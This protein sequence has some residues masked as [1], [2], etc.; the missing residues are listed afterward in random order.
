MNRGWSRKIGLVFILLACIL[1]SN[2]YADKSNRRDK[3]VVA[4]EK[5]SPAVVNISTYQKAAYR[6]N[7][8]FGFRDSIFDEFFKNFFHGVPEEGKKDYERSLGSGV[9]LSRKG[10]VLTNEHVVLKSTKIVV[11]TMDGTSYEAE[12]IGSDGTSDIAVLKIKLQKLLPSV[13]L[14]NSDDLMIGEKVIA[15][16]N[17]FKLSHT[18]TTGVISAQGR[19]LKVGNRVYTNFIQTDTSI[20]PGNSGGPLIN[21]DGEVIGINT[22]IMSPQKS[23]GIGFAIPMN[24]AKRILDDLIAFGKVRKAWIGI[25]IQDLNPILKKNF[26]YQKNH[27][28]IVN[29]VEKK[30]PAE[31]SKIFIGDIIEKIG[32]S[33]I[34]SGNDFYN[35]LNEYTAS[36]RIVFTV[37][38]DG[39]SRIVDVIARPF[40]DNYALNIARNLI[41]IKVKDYKKYG[42][43][44]SFIASK[45]IAEKIGFA[46][47]DVII[48]IDR[49]R[50]K[51]V[52]D[53]KDAMINVRFKN[54]I[55]IEI[56]RGRYIY[57]TSI[58]L[59]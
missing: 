45:S 2:L 55:Y 44:I 58:P 13:S 25:H 16:G 26:G 42:V 56:Q 10:Y 3:V 54:S 6:S 28:V 49:W 23:Q 29:N 53:F 24:T 32:N 31:R 48:K 34:K 21:I 27:G 9:I 7:P 1:A 47:G 33:I 15:I 52:S 51:N 36:D 30:S 20:N 41:G 12:V 19:S 46:R 39:K 14:G 5:V 17:P 35:V 57:Q 43:V 40:P 22:A 8:F 18:V 11:T 4:V 38:R 37:Y 50:I 59:K